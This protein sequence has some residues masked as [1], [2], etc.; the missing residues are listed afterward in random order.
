MTF[1]VSITAST[2]VQ[3]GLGLKQ[4]YFC[5]FFAVCMFRLQCIWPQ[6]R[7]LSRIQKPI[8]IC[9]A[10]FTV[11]QYQYDTY[12]LSCS[13]LTIPFFISRGVFKMRRQFNTT[14]PY[15]GNTKYDTAIL[16]VNTMFPS[17]LFTSFHTG[18]YHNPCH[19]TFPFYFTFV[20]NI[21][22][23]QGSAN[24]QSSAALRKPESGAALPLI[25]F[26]GNW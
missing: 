11:W 6:G 4:F 2:R 22:M 26:S 12:T 20:C 25:Y 21:E 10:V 23:W 18:R 17:Y 14:A 13:A 16:C 9:H 1:I 19:L 5:S 3:D 8:M 24:P 15:M 7:P